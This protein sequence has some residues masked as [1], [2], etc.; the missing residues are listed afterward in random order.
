MLGNPPG[1]RRSHAPV[2]SRGAAGAP[3]YDSADHAPAP[4]AVPARKALP[5]PAVVSSAATT[6]VTPPPTRRTFAT[7]TDADW[8][9]GEVPDN[10]PAGVA[11]P[12]RAPQFSKYGGFASKEE[13]IAERTSAKDA[14]S[15]GFFLPGHRG[16]AARA[17]D[18]AS[19]EREEAAKQ[20]FGYR[21]WEKRKDAQAAIARGEIEHA[22]AIA[23][24][25]DLAKSRAAV[26]VSYAHGAADARTSSGGAAIGGPFGGGAVGVGASGASHAASAHSGAFVYDGRASGG[27][28]AASAPLPTLPTG[29]AAPPVTLPK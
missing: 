2:R 24:A 13:Y 11:K 20:Y 22:E 9:A 8:E 5:G 29:P 14:S 1:L 15:K 6:P 26:M 4:T 3:S 27:A 10:W 7:M 23:V 28:G 16:R 17:F 12:G 21:A 19:P 25:H 18:S